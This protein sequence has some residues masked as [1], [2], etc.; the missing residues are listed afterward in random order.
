MDTCLYCNTTTNNPI[1]LL[2]LGTPQVVSMCSDYCAK[3]LEEIHD[4]ERLE[5]DNDGE[6]PYH[7]A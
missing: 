2:I 4:C 7:P 3:T 6:G 5:D 1:L